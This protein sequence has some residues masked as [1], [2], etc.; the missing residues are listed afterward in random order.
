MTSKNLLS[1]DDAAHLLR[2]AGFGGTMSEIQAFTGVEREEA[3]G[4]LVNYEMSP[5]VFDNVEYLMAL[6]DT[7]PDHLEKNGMRKTPV[8]AVRFWWIV[9]MLATTN[10][11]EE[12][13]TL[14]WHNHFTSN[15][16]EGSFMFGQNQ[17]FRTHGLGNFKEL[18]LDVSRDPEMLRYLN[19]D[20]NYK[21]HPNE[22]YGRELMELF[23]CGRVDS[24][25]KPNY[26]EDDV[27]A[28]A[29]AFSGWNMRGREFFFNPRQHDDMAKT[30]MGH[31]G[32]LNGDDVVDILLAL[33]ATANH[34]CSKLYRYFVSDAPD[35]VLLR[36]L[37]KTYFDSKYDIKAVVSEIFLSDEFWSKKARFALI[38]SPAEYVVG[39]VRT[40]GLSELFI[41][42]MDDLRGLQDSPAIEVP[43]RGETSL[44]RLNL[45]AGSMNQMAQSLLAPPSV[46]GWDGGSM[47]INTNTIQARARF[48]AALSQIGVVRT[49]VEDSF[50][51]DRVSLSSAKL[52]VDRILR[53]IGP[54]DLSGGGYSALLNYAL[55]IQNPGERLSGALALALAS[56][57][58]QLC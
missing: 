18:T 36:R 41:P 40:L 30:F 25:G 52:V 58:A 46:K 1:F 12:K 47:W 57:E 3:V 32:N 39:S 45:L 33:P 20:R 50:N 42:S 31:T 4:R 5:F 10:P 26:T 9:R 35:P 29:R 15:D 21:E 28:A 13:I 37:T 17:L 48:A 51:E 55:S 16:G 11:L 27:K 53:I 14:F 49:A 34:I 2:R 19:G 22:N 38:K 54:I 8:Q 44:S 43:R 24:N 6:I 23:T 7:M 56:P